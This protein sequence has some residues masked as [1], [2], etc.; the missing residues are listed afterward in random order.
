M[1]GRVLVVDDDKSMTELLSER[2]KRRQF[3]VVTASDGE[4]ALAACL[5]NPPDLVLTD[6]MMA[7][8]DGFGL[9][10][11]LRRDVRTALLP[12]LLISARAGED[13]RIETAGSSRRRD[14]AAD[15]VQQA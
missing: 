11:R 5:A 2:L 12:I 6:V 13:A 1:K 9:V 7:K 4:K 14:S 10:A 3:E 15:E 8:L